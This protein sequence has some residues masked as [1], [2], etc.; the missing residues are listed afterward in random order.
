MTR[1][2]RLLV[3]V[4]AV[5]LA[6]ACGLP[7]DRAPRVIAA[8]DAPLD[9]AQI[10][11]QAAEAEGNER[12]ELYFVRG[13]LLD[14]VSRLAPDG[15]LATVLR[16][17]IAGPLEDEPDLSTRISPS[18]TELREA[19]VDGGIA[20]IDIGCVGDAPPDQCGLLAFGGQDQ[21]TLF[22]QLT[23]T[24]MDVTG[25]NGVRFLQEGQ[26]QDAPTEASG[27]IQSPGV[28]T[29]NDYPSLLP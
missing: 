17:L 9:L 25:I 16:L 29:C 11:G 13:G 21:I 19:E 12:V 26:P 27:T 5:A 10:P 28:V 23:C 4:A 1:A 14:S 2:R 3:V 20:I 8:D 22:A 6:G 24:A 15:E 18:E 7:N